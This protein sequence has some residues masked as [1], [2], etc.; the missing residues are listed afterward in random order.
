[1]KE[2]RCK[3]CNH[4]FSKDVKL[5]AGMFYMNPS[6]PLEVFQEVRKCP[7]CGALNKVTIEL[8]LTIKIKLV[9][10]K[11]LDNKD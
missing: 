4:C 6:R 9:E 1:M 10:E 2:I 5:G 3:S 11:A 8:D 7:S